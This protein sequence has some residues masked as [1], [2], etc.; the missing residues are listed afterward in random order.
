MFARGAV[1]ACFTYEPFL[2]EAAAHGGSIIWSTRDLPGYMIDV[3]V[4]TERAIASRRGDLETVVSAWY[5][6]QQ[7]I[8][9]HPEESFAL[10]GAR[11]GMSAKEF[12]AFYRSFTLFSAR[13]NREIFA[14]AG[15]RSVLSEMRD[16]LLSHRAIGSGFAV[17]E[18]FTDRIA[19]AAAARP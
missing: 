7:Y 4:A 16:F 2:G 15:F 5:R 12:G 9:E 1:D 17:D 14:S 13:Q 3:L 6:A 8:E 18:V 10:M 19:N 11:E